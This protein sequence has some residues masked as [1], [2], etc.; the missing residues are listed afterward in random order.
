[1]SKMFEPLKIKSK[2]AKNRVVFPPV[3]VFDESV[4]DGVL[5]D[6]VIDHYK[7]VAKAGCSILITEATCIEKSARLSPT[8]LGIW[9]DSFI[10]GLSKL[11]KIA[12]D[13]DAIALIQIMHAGD[14]THKEVNTTPADPSNLSINE[15]EHIFQQFIDAGLRAK[16]AGYDGVELHA[17]HGYLLNQFLSPTTNNRDDVY[18]QDRAKLTVDIIKQLRQKAGDDFII[19]VR[20]PGNDPDLKT[21][22]AY[23]KKFEE[24]GADLFHISAGIPPEKPADM[25][26]KENDMHNWIVQL[27]IEIKK[28]VSK[29]VIAVNGIRTPEQARYILQHV[30]FVALAKGY[31]CDFS[32][33]EKAKNNEPVNECASCKNCIRFKGAYKCLQN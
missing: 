18:G 10:E 1:M 3:V 19:A 14:K 5:T 2:T 15:I 6:D 8:Q 23:A 22:I 20:M 25:D 11:A 30:D 31:L 26:Y 32:W 12:H 29:P 28:H 13:E 9:D 24:A 33:I 16:K 17:C 4:K 21:S 7:R 27:G